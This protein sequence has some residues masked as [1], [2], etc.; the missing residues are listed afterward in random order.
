MCL[1]RSQICL[2]VHCECN[3]WPEC[4]YSVHVPDMAVHA[5]RAVVCALSVSGPIV[6]NSNLVLNNYHY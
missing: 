1:P 5:I 3:I 4:L 6:I 2:H